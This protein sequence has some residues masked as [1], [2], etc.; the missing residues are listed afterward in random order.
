MSPSEYER[1]LAYMQSM[2]AERRRR[3]AARILSEL[4]RES[5]TECC[6][7]CSGSGR[8]GVVFGAVDDR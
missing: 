4:T 1:Y 8:V 7:V 2:D 5:T 3:A 6:P